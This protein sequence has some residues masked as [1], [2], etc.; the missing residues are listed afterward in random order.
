LLPVDGPAE[1]VPQPTQIAPAT[2]IPIQAA[3]E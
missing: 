1:F 3:F 2:S